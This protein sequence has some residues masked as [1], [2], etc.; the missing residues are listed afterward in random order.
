MTNMSHD[1]TRDD[2]E[3][4][5]APPPGGLGADVMKANIAAELFGDVVAPLQIGRYEVGEAIG[6][7]AMGLV[8]AAWDPALGRRTALKVLSAQGAASEGPTPKGAVCFAITV[9]YITAPV[10]LSLSWT[11]LY[12][13]KH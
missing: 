11:H 5:P 12:S 3:L 10:S 13:I 7:G 9:E 6:Q 1:S 2:S 8:Y 4:G